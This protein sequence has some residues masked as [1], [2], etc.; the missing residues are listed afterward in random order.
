MTL[1]VIPVVYVS[2]TGIETVLDSSTDLHSRQAL[3]TNNDCGGISQADTP[4]LCGNLYLITKA[5]NVRE[6]PKQSIDKA[7]PIKPI[8]RTGLRPIRSDILPHCRMVA[9]CTA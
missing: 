1:L 9:A 3:H 2:L 7:L 6:R 4:L 5:A 8:R